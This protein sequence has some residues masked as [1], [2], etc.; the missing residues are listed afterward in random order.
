MR[1][2]SIRKYLRVLLSLCSAFQIYFWA[3]CNNS[4]VHRQ[5]IYCNFGV[6]VTLFCEVLQVST[7]SFKNNLSLINL[8]DLIVFYHSSFLKYI[9]CEITVQIHITFE[10]ET[11]NTVW[12]EWQIWWG[13]S[14]W[15]WN[16]LV[17]WTVSF[18][19][20]L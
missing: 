2:K 20:Y 19:W 1:F 4:L 7:K 6:V 11:W 12:N 14:W 10:H 18:R 16:V 5:N 8:F 9:F 13:Y 17:V 15:I 3:V